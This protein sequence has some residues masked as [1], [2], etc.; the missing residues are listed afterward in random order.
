MAVYLIRHGETAFNAKRVVQHPETPLSEVG[1]RQAQ[2]LAER[3]RACDFSCILTSD[4]QRALQTAEPLQQST[5]APLVVE[6]LLRERNFGLHRGQTYEALQEQG[7]DLFAEHYAPPGGE[8]GID[9]QQRVDA[10]FARIAARVAEAQPG[11]G[12]AVVTHGLV[13][14]SIV[15]RKARV[16]PEMET[17][18]YGWTNTSVTILEP[19]APWQ[20]TLLN[21][22]RHLDEDTTGRSGQRSAP[23]LGKSGARV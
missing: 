19:G 15:A 22:A 21:C 1:K 12:L 17:P 8:H 16:L 18:G 23:S 2:Q 7:I 3:L 13:C 4:Y 20:V 6:P 9:F 5:R 14:Q 11:Q 10:A